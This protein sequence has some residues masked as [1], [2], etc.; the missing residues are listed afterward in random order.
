ML[1]SDFLKFCQKPLE[2]GLIGRFFVKNPLKT[3]FFGCKFFGI[4]S[5]L[6]NL[7]YATYLYNT[8]AKIRFLTLFFWSV[9]IKKPPKTGL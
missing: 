5:Y 2:N 4:K 3:V 9:K 6:K 7:S 1:K 8:C